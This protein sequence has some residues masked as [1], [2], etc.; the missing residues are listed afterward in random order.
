MPLTPERSQRVVA[1][2]EEMDQAGFGH[3][4]NTLECGAV[5]P[6]EI[7]TDTISQLNREYMNAAILGRE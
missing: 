3:C 4:S 1:M 2:V 6:K 5:C 7:S